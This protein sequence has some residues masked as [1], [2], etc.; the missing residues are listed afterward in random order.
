LS[1]L[2]I[3]VPAADSQSYGGDAGGRTYSENAAVCYRY[4]FLLSITI[5]RSF[6][7]IVAAAEVDKNNRPQIKNGARL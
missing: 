1:G 6:G 7:F 3:R 4:L 5:N 2:I